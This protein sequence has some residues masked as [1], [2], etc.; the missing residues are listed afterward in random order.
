[1]ARTLVSA[2]SRLISTLFG[3]VRR[4]ARASYARPGTP[5]LRGAKQHEAKSVDTIVDAAGKSARAT[6]W[7]IHTMDHI[8]ATT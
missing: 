3:V 4:A 1:V 8:T 2:A 6:S 5:Y 7:L